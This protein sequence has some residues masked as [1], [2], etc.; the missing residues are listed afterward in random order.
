MKK[1]LFATLLAGMMS[2]TGVTP[3][4]ASDTGASIM[5]TPGT[6]A[7]AYNISQL[8]AGLEKSGFSEEAAA[9]VIGCMMQKSEANPSA[10][11]RTG[12]AIGLMQ[13]SGSRKERLQAYDD[14]EC[15]SSQLHYMLWECEY[16]DLWISCPDYPEIT[17][18]QFKTWSNVEEAVTIFTDCY[19]RP[20]ATEYGDT[21]RYSNAQ[22][23]YSTFCESNLVEVEYN[24]EDWL[25][26]STILL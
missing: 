18:D 5:Y 12:D 26:G 15:I 10:I 8:W 13:W 25:D 20:R 24:W 2:I 11:N 7:S 19:D 1:R 16:A 6:G 21:G 4:M 14:W 22:L 9:A 3:V 23:V 17:F